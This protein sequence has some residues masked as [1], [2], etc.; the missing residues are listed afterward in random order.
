MSKA[1]LLAFIFFSPTFAAAATDAYIP[2]ATFSVAGSTIVG[3]DQDAAGNLY[4]LAAVPGV[5]VAPGNPAPYTVTSYQTPSM[6][7]EL[8]FSVSIT[9]PLAFAVQPNGTVDIVDAGNA[10]TFSQYNNAGTLLNQA[11]RILPYNGSFYTGAIDKAN[12]VFYVSYKSSVIQ[13]VGDF[14]FKV[15]YYV[16]AVTKISFSGAEQSTFDLPG[17]TTIS[18]TCYTPSLMTVDS[19]STL[20]IADQVCDQVLTYNTAGTLGQT[21]PLIYTAYP[22]GIWPAPGG[23]IFVPESTCGYGY[24][25]PQ[26][27]SWEFSSGGAQLGSVGYS[28]QLGQTWDSRTLYLASAA[29]SQ[30]QRDIL[31]YAPTAPVPSGLQGSVT[32]H[33]A[34][35]SLTWQAANDSDGDAILYSVYVGTS[36][37]SMAFAGSTTQTSFVTAALNF[38]VNYFWQ[39]TAQDSYMGLPMLTSTSAVDSFTLNFQNS[40]PGAF[41]VA[42]GSGMA[43]TRSTT[44]TF[45]WTASVDPDGDPVTYTVTWQPAGSSATVVTTAANSLTVSGLTFG[46]RVSWSVKACDPYNACTPMS[47]GSQSYQPVFENLPPP[48]PVVTGGTGSLSEHTLTPQASLSWAASVDPDGDPVAYRVYVGTTP[49]A[50]TLAQ[51][52]TQTNYALTG[53]AFGKTYYWQATAY[54]PYGGTGTTPTQSLVV[55]LQNAAPAAFTILTGTGTAATRGTTQLLSWTSA[56][57][58]DGDAVTY[59]VDAATS[60]AAL[61]AT[62]SGEQRLPAYKPSFQSSATRRR[63]RRPIRRRRARFP[64]TASTRRCRSFGGLRATRTGTRSLTASPTGRAAASS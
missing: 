51:D 52:S 30:L 10:L 20:W 36:S 37:N 57:D 55:Q 15:L 23:N 46:T 31:D 42:S 2:Q 47:G 58:P 3:M 60:P 38:G 48:A 16:G 59:E 7:P 56:V 8:S 45:G 11:A 34:T 63:P 39:V 17:R 54:D 64:T 49:N 21:F 5:N 18:T 33:A 62:A 13:D 50:L 41:S 44:A 28:S 29:G 4:V 35:A 14:G 24:A 22:R 27:V 9:T 12:S 19:Q 25:C 61:L 26:L 43:V 53:M 6:T 40:A 1:W 32:Q